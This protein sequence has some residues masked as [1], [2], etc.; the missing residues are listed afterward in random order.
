MVETVRT[1][2]V[3]WHGDVLELH[4]FCLPCGYYCWEEIRVKVSDAFSVAPTCHNKV[5]ICKNMDTREAWYW[6]A[7]MLA[8]TQQHP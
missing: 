5:T 7:R 1:A 4:A 2:Y 6:I 8:S 3:G